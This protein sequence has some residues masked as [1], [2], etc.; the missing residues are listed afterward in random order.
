MNRKDIT[1]MA[2][3]ASIER[4]DYSINELEHFAAL[5]A[6]AERKACKKECDEIAERFGGTARDCSDAIRARGS[7]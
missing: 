4:I 3:K 7:K 2:Q 5:V 1:K 6:A